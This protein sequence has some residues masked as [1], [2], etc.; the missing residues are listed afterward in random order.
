MEDHCCY[1]P[2]YS[3]Q[4]MSKQ[5]AIDCEPVHKANAALPIK[6]SLLVTLVLLLLLDKALCGT[7]VSKTC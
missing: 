2:A 4:E 6:K 1:D 5:A 7:K 3:Q